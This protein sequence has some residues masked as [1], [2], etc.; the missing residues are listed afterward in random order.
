[1][2]PYTFLSINSSGPEPVRL[3][4]RFEAGD[5]DL[6][7]HTPLSKAGHKQEVVKQ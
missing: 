2:M 1:M 6:S 3:H 5:V 7:S 4:M